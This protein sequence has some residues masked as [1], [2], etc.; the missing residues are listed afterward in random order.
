MSNV[1][2]MK[3]YKDAAKYHSN[4]NKRSETYITKIIILLKRTDVV[5]FLSCMYMDLYEWHQYFS[6]CRAVVWQMRENG[7][8]ER[9]D[10]TEKKT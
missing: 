1:I 2:I 10:E 9:V 7:K 4:S 3:I 8:H 5:L 6:H